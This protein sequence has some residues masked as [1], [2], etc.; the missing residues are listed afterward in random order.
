[1]SCRLQSKIYFGIRYFN[2]KDESKGLVS[3]TS[4]K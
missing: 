3:L 2:F 4:N 1:M